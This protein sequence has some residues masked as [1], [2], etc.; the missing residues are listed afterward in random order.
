VVHHLRGNSSTTN[1]GG[2]PTGTAI[3]GDNNDVDHHDYIIV[4]DL[5]GDDAGDK[6]DDED[7]GAT[8]VEPKDAELFE[9]IA[10]RHDEDDVL[11]GNS[12]WLEN[13]RDMKQSITDPLYEKGDC[14]KHMMVISSCL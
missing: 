3:A 8:L 2:P 5:F 9:N 1:V 7:V 10:I 6:G 11:F 14:L 4:E 12:M 13:S